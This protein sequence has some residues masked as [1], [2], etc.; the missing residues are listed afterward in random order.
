MASVP[1]SNPIQTKIQA[2]TSGP[3]WPIHFV[4][5][6]PAKRRTNITNLCGVVAYLSF[7]LA[8]K[9]ISSHET[10]VCKFALINCKIS[11]IN[12][13]RRTGDPHPGIFTLPLCFFF[14]NKFLLKMLFT[15]SAS[16]V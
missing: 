4:A 11:R 3:M 15:A 5:F 6:M 13:F 12:M 1:Q 8:V 7:K 9:C 16:G 14:W 2:A 10:P